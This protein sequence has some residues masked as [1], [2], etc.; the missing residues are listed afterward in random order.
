MPLAVPVA[1]TDV[2]L[3]QMRGPNGPFLMHVQLSVD[4]RREK[5]FTLVRETLLRQRLRAQTLFEVA[6]QFRKRTIQQGTF[7]PQRGT[8]KDSRRAGSLK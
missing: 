1:T 6:S 8:G 4:Q 2:S 7:F 5:T 3:I